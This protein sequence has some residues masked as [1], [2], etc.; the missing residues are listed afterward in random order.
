[1]KIGIIVAV[2]ISL[3][4]GALYVANSGQT[5]NSE[6]AESSQSTNQLAANTVVYDVRTPEEFAAGRAVDAINLP[7]ESIADGIYP[8]VDKDTPI[9]VYCRSG[10]RS[11][12]ATTILTQAG[13]TNITDIGAF[14]SLE[15]YGLATI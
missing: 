12:Q 3:F 1:M 10:N 4:G 14:E 8:D 11:G 9:A 2:L 7:I 6:Q 15:D 5:E 13:F